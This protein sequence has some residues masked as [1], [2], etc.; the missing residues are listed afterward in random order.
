MFIT[1]DITLFFFNKGFNLRISFSLNI[2]DY[3][4]IRKRLDVIQIEDI[5]K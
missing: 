5:I 2:T 1:I 3:N 4:S